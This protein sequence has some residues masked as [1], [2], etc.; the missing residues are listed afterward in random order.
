MWLSDAG[1]SDGVVGLNTGVYYLGIALT[2]IAVP[3]LMRRMGRSC[4]ALGFVLSGATVILFPWGASLFGWF[5]LRLLN[6]IGGAM[7]LIPLET[8]VNRHSP[9]EQRSRNF[10]L[11]AV[12]IAA[13]WRWAIS[14]VCKCTTARR[15]RLSYSAAS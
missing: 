13:G 11:Y 4:P 1:H 5:V 14:S 9:A 6:G 7:S 2:A 8:Y 12:A 3:W 15:A 10:G